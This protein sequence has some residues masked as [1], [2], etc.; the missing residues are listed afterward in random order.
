MTR[1]V[2]VIIGCAGLIA[3][4]SEGRYVEAESALSRGIAFT[5]QPRTGGP[6]TDHSRV[7][8]AS[9]MSTVVPAPGNVDLDSRIDIDVN[10]SMLRLGELNI[11]DEQRLIDLSKRQMALQG[12][13]DAIA[14]LLE[15]RVAVVEAYEAWKEAIGNRSEEPAAFQRF[16]ALLTEMNDAAEDVETATDG[17]WPEVGTDEAL[18]DQVDHAF[19][20]IGSNTDA[21]DLTQAAL[22]ELAAETGAILSAVGFEIR[23]EA[24]LQSAGK[25]A[26][27]VHLPG[28]DNLPAGKLERRD[29]LGLAL[30]GAELVR[31]E[32][33]TRQ[34]IE[35]AT[36]GERV[37]IGEQS[38]NEAFRALTE[39]VLGDVLVL[40]A[41]GMRLSKELELDELRL[42]IRATEAAART[43]SESTTRRLEGAARSK[44]EE[45]KTLAENAARGVQSELEGANDL[46]LLLSEIAELKSYV[47]NPSPTMLPR[48]QEIL[49]KLPAQARSLLESGVDAAK[50]RT[51]G[52]A[53]DVERLIEQAPAG[54]RTIIRDEWDRSDLKADVDKWGALVNDVLA[55]VERL[56]ELEQ[57]G[58]FTPIPADLRVPGVIDVPL[59][60]APDTYVDLE[61]TPRLEGDRLSLRTTLLDGGQIVGEPYEAS[62]EIQR[63]G[64]HAQLDPAVVL[65]RPD[66]LENADENFRFA[67][68]LGWLHSYT[69][70][71]DGDGRLDDFWRATDM[72]FGPHAAF[73]SFDSEKEI[74]IGLGATLGLWDGTL[75][76]GV[77]WNLNADSSDDGGA[78]YYVGSSLIALLQS[79]QRE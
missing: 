10:T 79:F 17:V 20:S 11:L 28:Y 54:I 9:N 62:F 43:L 63:Y 77:G 40:A 55:Y 45:I 53:A 41:D 21:R 60:G 65:V 35:L 76:F 25:E 8:E 39:T 7:D 47:D 13:L 78:Y 51:V 44:V 2:R 31:F 6:G 68:V 23:M 66:Q 16:R 18:Q 58:Q 52:L 64:W 36:A 24:F 33:L 74:E 56:E 72:S 48:L 14:V 32:E 61:R 69:P 4:Q 46:S 67:P 73:L 59:D 75:Q 57:L 15:R 1:F 12:L 30:E 37:R 3:C 49:S 38:L 5:E 29:R 70:R 50:G 27:P 26:I 42:R 22:D 19:S 34:S 71:P